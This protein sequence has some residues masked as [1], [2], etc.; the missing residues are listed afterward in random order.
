[1]TTV[2][3]VFYNPSVLVKHAKDDAGWRVVTV[4]GKPVGRVVMRGKGRY[5]LELNNGKRAA[6]ES[7]MALRFGIDKLL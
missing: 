5:D 4:N 6:F 3:T 1:M 2:H 7:L